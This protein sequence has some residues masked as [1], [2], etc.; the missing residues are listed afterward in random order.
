MFLEKLWS[1]TGLLLQDIVFKQGINIIYGQ[2][3]HRE[4]KE[5]SHGI[6]GIGKSSVIRLIDYLLLSETAK[7]VFNKKDYAFLPKGNHEIC[8]SLRDTHNHRYIIRR[9][10]SDPRNVYFHQDGM[11]ESSYTE[12]ELKIILQNLF[13]P[14]DG[15]IVMPDGH[16]R[17]LM[18]FFI[19]DD[20][21]HYKRENPFEFISHRGAKKSLITIANLFLLGIDNHQLIKLANYGEKIKNLQEKKKF[22]A[23]GSD[24]K[25]EKDMLQW[26]SELRRKAL[27]LEQSEQALSMFNLSQSYQKIS[28][29][30]VEID[31]KIISLRKDEQRLHR[32]LEKLQAFT[33]SMPSEIDIDYIKI[34]YAQVSHALASIVSRTIEEVLEFR[35]SLA[36]ERQRFHGEQLD[37]LKSS[38][39]R[40]ID[41]L[42]QLDKQRAS[43]LKTVGDDFNTSYAKA[44]QQIAKERSELEIAQS[45]LIEIENIDKEI[46]HINVEMSQLKKQYIENIEQQKRTI[47]DIVDIYNKVI[48]AAFDSMNTMGEHHY[49]DFSIR[50]N[51]RT[52]QLP[53]DIKMDIPRTDALGRARLKLVLYDLTVFF[54]ALQTERQ[55]PHFLVQDG[56]FHSV[57]LQQIVNIL[58]FIKEQSQIYPFQYIT[59]FN[60]DEYSET[61]NVY[62]VKPE[63]SL[64]DQIILRLYDEP[65]KMLFM[66]KFG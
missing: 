34:Q 38:H 7:Q 39:H 35:A 10:F 36:V 8:L 40:V 1:P 6:N 18:G 22:L 43:L 28:Q 65:D 13:F 44:W 42:Q 21:K 45:K 52:N 26:Q 15:N 9:Q 3:S 49:L 41:E 53:I 57:A 17:E 14:P 20:L 66:R 58:N 16:Y 25:V 37:A 64:D 29:T 19:K 56:V 2:Y 59:T 11:P 61:Q 4:K 31:N 27:Q 5:R 54:H 12:A 23:S 63:F 24:N 32:Q 30:V 48:D 60:E 46:S 51:T 55:L 50:A 62:G 47:N 33:R